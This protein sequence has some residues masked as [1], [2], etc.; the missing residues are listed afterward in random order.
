MNPSYRKLQ[1]K[2]PDFRI[3]NPSEFSSQ[4]SQGHKRVSPSLPDSSS[5]M[6][7]EYAMMWDNPEDRQY[8]MARFKSF[9]MTGLSNMNSGNQV[10]PQ[11]QLS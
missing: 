2:K 10:S 9:D 1:T 5:K 11:K 8:I 6:T 4:H 7:A 3:N